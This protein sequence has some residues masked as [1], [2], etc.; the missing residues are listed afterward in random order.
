MRVGEAPTRPHIAGMAGE[1]P[2][3][4]QTVQRLRALEPEL[5][6]RGLISLHL[7]GSVARDRASAG[8]DVD[9]FAEFAPGARLGWDFAGA[10]T[11]LSEHLGASVDLTTRSALHP[12][13]RGDIERE[14]IRIF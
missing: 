14:A 13:L 1:A 11:L 2:S 6:A 12:L 8:S 5:R 3:R 7:F 10:P 4:D 9:L